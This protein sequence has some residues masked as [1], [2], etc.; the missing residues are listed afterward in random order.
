MQHL[1]HTKITAAER[2]SF[3]CCQQLVDR[4]FFYIAHKCWLVEYPRN[5]GNKTILV[6]GGT[7]NLTLPNAS[8]QGSILRNFTKITLSNFGLS[9]TNKINV[10]YF[11]YSGK[12]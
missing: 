3:S 9:S 11:T 8:N 10:S 7:L 4:W 1:N 5:S 6:A 12:S 2:S